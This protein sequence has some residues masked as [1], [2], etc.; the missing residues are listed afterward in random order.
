[1]ANEQERS[2]RANATILVDDPSHRLALDSATEFARNLTQ[3][4]EAAKG[5]NKDLLTDVPLLYGSPGPLASKGDPGIVLAQIHR[6]EIVR[7]NGGGF[8]GFRAEESPARLPLE[9]T[10]TALAMLLAIIYFLAR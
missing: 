1:M 2:E 4:G 9:R 5:L 6:E 3:R 8:S 10:T 7:K